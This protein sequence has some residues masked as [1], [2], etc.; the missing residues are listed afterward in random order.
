MGVVQ[1]LGEFLPI[2]SSAHLA[3][4]PLF[5]NFKDPGLTFSVALHFGT[6]LALVLYFWRDY[7]N[8]FKGFW[9]CL[10]AR[11]ATSTTDRTHCN[12]LIFLAIATVPGAVAGYFLDEL[13]ETTFRHPILI[14]VNMSLLGVLL[15]LAE[16]Q[17]RGKKGL[18]EVDLRAAVLIG[19]S[20]ALALMPGV[21]RAGITI[22]AGLFWGLSRVE[23]ARFS[24][25]MAVPIIFGAFV[26]KLK[27]L[28]AEPMGA[29]FWLGMLSS[30][31]VGYLSIKYLLR[32]VR[33]YT[34]RPFVYYR[35]GF[36]AV[37]LFAY[38]LR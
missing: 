12:L 27:H 15:L 36:T 13:A 26:F 31:V 28:M 33:T 37:T 14:A 7:W 25:L 19:L 11:S 29:A 1:G 5:L 18:A 17:C 3:I 23:A 9:K 35:F 4:F 24:F 21:S 38:F 16:M 34:Y 8:L 30:A 20:Q 6:L 22:T 2:S 32:W 10:S